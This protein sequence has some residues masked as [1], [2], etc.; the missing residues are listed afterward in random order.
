MV[1]FSVRAASTITET[2]RKFDSTPVDPTDY[3]IPVAAKDSTTP[4]YRKRMAAKSN[5]P[6]I[7]NASEGGASQSFEGFPVREGAFLSR[8]AIR[9]A[10]FRWEFPVLLFRVCGQN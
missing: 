8:E 1:V 7:N 2:P 6:G 9:E 3:H 5:R 4:R 10:R